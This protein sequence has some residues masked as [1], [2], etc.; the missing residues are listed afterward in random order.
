VEV[1]QGSASDDDGDGAVEDAP[2]GVRVDEDGNVP[3]RALIFF[4]IFFTRGCC[5][6]DPGGVE[7]KLVRPEEEEEEEYGEPAAVEVSQ[8]SAPEDDGDGAVEDAPRGVHVDEDG[9]VPIPGPIA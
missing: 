6:R 5:A 3:I 4:L 8:G 1:S 9:N 2:R 7:G